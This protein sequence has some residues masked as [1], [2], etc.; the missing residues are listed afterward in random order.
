MILQLVYL[1]V[2]RLDQLLGA[3]LRM[4]GRHDGVQKRIN[5]GDQSSMQAY[6]QLTIHQHFVQSGGLIGYPASKQ[7]ETAGTS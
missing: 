3:A 7:V 4:H 2:H 5:R 1:L 6:C